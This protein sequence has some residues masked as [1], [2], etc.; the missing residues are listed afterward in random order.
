MMYKGMAAMVFV[1]IHDQ[2]RFV[3]GVGVFNCNKLDYQLQHKYGSSGLPYL[4][5]Q[6]Q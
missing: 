5:I 1:S 4:C 6:L 2:Y 3:K